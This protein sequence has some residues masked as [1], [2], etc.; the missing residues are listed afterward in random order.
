MEKEWWTSCGEGDPWTLYG[1]LCLRIVFTSL[2]LL[3]QLSFNFLSSSSHGSNPSSYRHHRL[4]SRPCRCLI[5]H[6]FYFSSRTEHVLKHPSKLKFIK[7]FFQRAIV[8]M[9]R[10]LNKRVVP[11]LL[12]RCNMSNADFRLCNAQ[13]FRH[14]SL[15]RSSKLMILDAL[16]RRFEGASEY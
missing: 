9:K 10:V 3:T 11:I 8:R 12:R 1:L 6:N 2:P 13:C 7:L 16:E 4:P 15:Y 5:F 14:I